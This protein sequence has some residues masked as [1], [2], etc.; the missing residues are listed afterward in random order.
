MIS[1]RQLFCGAFALCAAPLS[2][3]PAPAPLPV[4]TALLADT[5][6]YDLLGRLCDDFGGRLTGSPASE[7]AMNALVGELRTLGLK[8]E[9]QK[10]T[11]PGWVRGDDEVTMVA[12]LPAP[13]RLRVAALSYTQ[14]HAPFEAEIVDIGQ[15]RDEDFAKI[16]A[17][18]KIGLLAANTSVPRGL[19][20]KAA[21]ERGMR[22]VLFINREGGGQLLARTGAFSGEPLKIPVYSLAQEEGKWIGRLLARGQSVRLRMHT[23]SHCQ[24]V[25]TT[26]LIVR[27]PGRTAEKIVLGAHFDSW[28]LGQG[29]MDNGIG[30]AQLFA[31]AKYLAA[32]PA[33]RLRPIELI[34][35]NGEEQGLWGSRHAAAVA[36]KEPIAAMVNLDMVGYP[37]S[38]NACGDEALVPLLTRFAATMPVERLREGVKNVAWLASDHTPYQLDGVNVI[39]FGAHID[40]EVNR[41][42]H[43]VAD[44]FDKSDPKMIAESAATIGALALFLADAPDLTAAR[45][46]PAAVAD[47]VKIHGLAPRLTAMGLWP[48]PPADSR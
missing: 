6:G 30:L 36:R 38:V 26:N 9:L 42:Y 21:V 31:L 19:Y 28:D 48:L 25:E 5:S 1:L 43:D 8:P 29:A 3:Q 33:D 10:F 45:R 20:E 44:T 13:R 16:D 2:A 39:T 35:Y 24:T 34:W 40:R 18:G 41:Y 37:L 15:G 14:P 12:P 22:G 7:A 4:V 47:L 27:F 23:R 46:S 11:M 17:R 32:H